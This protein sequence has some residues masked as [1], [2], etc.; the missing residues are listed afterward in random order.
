MGTQ[1]FWVCFTG[2]NGKESGVSGQSLGF[3]L[4]GQME[5]LGVSGWYLDRICL[6][7]DQCF[8]LFLETAF[9]GL[10]DDISPG[11]VLSLGKNVLGKDQCYPCTAFFLLS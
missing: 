8:G 3:I 9:L 5:G 4:L 10:M 6:A 11:F 2:Q 7:K 1:E